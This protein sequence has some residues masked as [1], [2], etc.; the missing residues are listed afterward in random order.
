[1]HAPDHELVH[2]IRA[3]GLRIELHG[4]RLPPSENVFPTSYRVRWPDTRDRDYNRHLPGGAD[5]SRDQS[6]APGRDYERGPRPARPGR[7]RTRL[8]QGRGARP[9]IRDAA[10]DGSGPDIQPR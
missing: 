3:D 8:L 6:Q 2:R 1:D 9:R 5:G 4:T 10:G 7:A